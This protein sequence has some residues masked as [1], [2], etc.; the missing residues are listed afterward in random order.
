M[1]LENYIEAVLQ[2][3]D[4]IND[5]NLNKFYRLWKEFDP[6]AT[7]LIGYEQLS[8]FLD[9]LNNAMRIPKPNHIAIAYMNLPL[10][11]GRKIHCLNIL[12]VKQ[13][14]QSFMET[15]IFIYVLHISSRENAKNPILLFMYYFFK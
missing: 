6:K 5:D 2:E 15:S 11:E 4:I 3:N 12:K 9:L 7:Q 13:F 8:D 10:V 1:I 14:E